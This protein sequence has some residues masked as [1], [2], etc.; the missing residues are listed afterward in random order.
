LN[1]HHECTTDCKD[2]ANEDK[3]FNTPGFHDI[4]GV[5]TDDTTV[6]P[7]NPECKDAE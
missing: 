7:T 2:I 5:C 6:D 1:K 3:T 4:K